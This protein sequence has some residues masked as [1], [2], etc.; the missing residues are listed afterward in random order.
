MFGVL[1]TDFYMS[2]GIFPRN[3]VEK[4]YEIFFS[5]IEQKILAGVLKTDFHVS[6]VKLSAK[7]FEKSSI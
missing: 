6:G 2:V 3:F 1:K 7:L 4:S 5:D